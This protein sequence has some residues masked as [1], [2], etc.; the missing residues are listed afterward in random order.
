[1]ASDQAGLLFKDLVRRIVALISAA[2]AA[3]NL[4]DAANSMHNR[5]ILRGV[6]DVHLGEA[7]LA[8]TDLA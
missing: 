6:Y 3:L 2:V 4:A 1:M 7:R 5:R 8:D